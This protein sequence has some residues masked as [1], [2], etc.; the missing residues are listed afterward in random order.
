MYNNL[1]AQFKIPSSTPEFVVVPVGKGVR[2]GSVVSSS[3]YTNS[4]LPAQAQVA[5]SVASKGIEVSLIMYADDLLKLNRSADRLSKNFDVLSRDY[6]KVGLSF[7]VF[8]SVA[9]FFNARY[10]EEEIPLGDSAVKP[11]ESITYHGLPIGQSLYSTGTLLI[12]HEE[13]KIQIAC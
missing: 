9:V 3:L 10:Y 2:Q 12:R 4:V 11:Y 13:A 6:N 5:T 1:R 7:N 8:K